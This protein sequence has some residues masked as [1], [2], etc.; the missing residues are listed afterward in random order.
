MLLKTPFLAG[1]LISITEKTGRVI[2]FKRTFVLIRNQKGKVKEV[3]GEGA[4]EVTTLK[5]PEQLNF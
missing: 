1:L 5:A 2:G 3:M 4:Q